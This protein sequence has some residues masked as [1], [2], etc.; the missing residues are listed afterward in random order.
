VEQ[1]SRPVAVEQAF[2]ELGQRLLAAKAEHAKV[3]EF[4]EAL[5]HRDFEV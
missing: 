3:K 4:D 5:F 1:D 2:E